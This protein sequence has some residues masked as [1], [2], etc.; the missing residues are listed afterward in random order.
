MRPVLVR[1]QPPQPVFPFQTKDLSLRLCAVYPACTSLDGINGYG[2][3]QG[4]L[5]VSD[6]G[7]SYIQG[8]PEVAF[9]IYRFPTVAAGK[10]F[11]RQ[12]MTATISFPNSSGASC[13]AGFKVVP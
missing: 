3:P 4:P 12:T 1:V 2:G 5:S 10:Q 8:T 6:Y 11:G 7:D 13:P 9:D